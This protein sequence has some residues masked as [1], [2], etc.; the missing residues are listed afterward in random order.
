MR[1][2]NNATEGHIRMIV[3]STTTSRFGL[4]FL[5]LLVGSLC[6]HCNAQVACQVTADCEKVLP[7]TGDVECINGLCSNPFRRGCLQAMDR[8]KG[9]AKFQDVFATAMMRRRVTIRAVWCPPPCL[10]RTMR[11]EW[12]RAIGN[13]AFSCPG[14]FRFSWEKFFE[15]P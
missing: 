8:E 9:T 2:F 10:K 1:H 7:F 15:S 5:V 11:F 4:V 12:H 6:R 14:S 3:P 13:L